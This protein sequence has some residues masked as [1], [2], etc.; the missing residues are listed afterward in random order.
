[1]MYWNHQR[2]PNLAYLGKSGSGKSVAAQIGL[3]RV[4]QFVPNA[5]A[6]ICDFKQEY[7]YLDG[8]SG[9]YAGN[10][11]EALQTFKEENDRRMREHTSENDPF[12]VLLFSEYAAFLAASDRRTREEAIAVTSSL[13]M[14][15]RAQKMSVWLDL[16]RFDAQWMGSA[17]DSLTPIALNTLSV[18][19][20]RMTFP[21]F[22]NEIGP[23]GQNEGYFSDGTTLQKI[24]V[25]TVTRWDILHDDIKKLVE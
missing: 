25:P 20:K 3:G 9:Y 10:C 5:R 1:M 19:A 16:Q 18:E 17:R 15:V 4:Y 21:E 12:H 24:I 23:V 7:T 11:L 22:V 2:C 13:I 6:T 8:C 14:T